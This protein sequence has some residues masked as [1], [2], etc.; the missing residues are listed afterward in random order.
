MERTSRSIDRDELVYQVLLV[1]SI[2]FTSLRIFMTVHLAVGQ[3]VTLVSRF[4][5]ILGS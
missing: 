5:A 3:A 4:S 2:A 1:F